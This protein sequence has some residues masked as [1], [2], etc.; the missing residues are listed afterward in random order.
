MK[1]LIRKPWLVLVCSTLI[2]TA[3]VTLMVGWNAPINQL[4]AGGL[5]GFYIGIANYME[6]SFHSKRYVAVINAI[7]G[8]LAGL[9][10]GYLTD[11]T[12]SHMMWYCLGGAILGASSR[13]WIKHLVLI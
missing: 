6:M 11:E 13:F 4:I 10:L 12:G 2:T 8:L 5:V 1:H 9:G 3:L 7:I